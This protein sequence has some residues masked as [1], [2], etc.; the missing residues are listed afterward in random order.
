VQ[1]DSAVFDLSRLIWDC[2]DMVVARSRSKGLDIF[3]CV[4]ASAILSALSFARVLIPRAQTNARLTVRGAEGHVRQVG[5][6][7]VSVAR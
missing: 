1:A 6:R 5:G 2:L 7:R 3:H 4:Q